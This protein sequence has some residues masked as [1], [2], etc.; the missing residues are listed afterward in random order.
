MCFGSLLVAVVQ[1]IHFVLRSLAQG[2]WVLE[3]FVN[4]I[5]GASLRAFA[6]CGF[7][8]GGFRAWKRVGPKGCGVWVFCTFL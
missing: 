8:P 6:G 3:C 2:N 7:G 5:M 1:T 4:C